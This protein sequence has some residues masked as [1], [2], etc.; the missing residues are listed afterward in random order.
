MQ[1][2]TAVLDAAQTLT[3][4][5]YADT[6]IP[7]EKRTPDDQAVAGAAPGAGAVAAGALELLSDPAGG[8]APALESMAV[9]LDAHAERYAR[10]HGL[11]LAA[12][13]P[14]FVALPFAHRTALVE[15]LTAW[16]HPE[17]EMW[18]GLALFS[19]MAYDSA[20]HL[21]TA[22]ALTAGHPGLLALGYEPPDTDGLWRFERFSYGRQLAPPHPRTTA[23]GSPS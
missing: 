3:I 8:L 9:A 13:L 22:E 10:D 20:A 23:S 5:A 16:E 12:D 4:E 19:N 15:Q 14:G 21:H 2:G 17:H 7:G 18:V 1:P 6:I 11:T